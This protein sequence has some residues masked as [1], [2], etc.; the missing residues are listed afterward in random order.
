MGQPTYS[1]LAFVA[2]IIA[3]LATA[4]LIAAFQDANNDPPLP[5]EQSTPEIEEV[6]EIEPSDTDIDDDPIFAETNFDESKSRPRVCPIEN[7]IKKCNRVVV[8]GQIKPVFQNEAPWQ[9][10]LWAYHI[11][12]YT[13]A[14]FQQKPEWARRHKCGG[15]L[16][17]AQW[18]LTAA[19]CVTGDYKNIPFQA[20]IGSTSFT[21]L[22]GVQFY[23]ILQTFV[24]DRHDPIKQTND[25]ALLRIAPVKTPTAGF[26]S[27]HGMNGP[28]SLA[29]NDKASV[30]GFGR[31]KTT[32]G[33]LPSAILLRGDVFVW[34]DEKCKTAY[35]AKIIDSN[36]CAN[37]QR[38]KKSR[39]TDSCQGDSG[40]P[41]MHHNGTKRVQIGIVSWGEGCA[42]RGKPG[43]YTR[44]SSYLDW[45][46]R[47]TKGKAGKQSAR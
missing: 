35:G 6:E 33:T 7:G 10:S 9:V 8:A 31:T 11:T 38:N 45:I 39:V 41:L 40:G 3:I 23:K 16:I 27:L 42:L 21:N 22:D 13:R 18:I 12:N 24:H 20:R 15:T 37:N 14:E 46:W 47:T 30:Y 44:V 34:S 2:A 43:V 32:P 17:A 25:I 28:L 29:E 5:V 19:H 4:P 36:F 1:R 26:A